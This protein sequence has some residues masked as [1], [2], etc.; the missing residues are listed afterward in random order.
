MKKE[1]E[2]GG[3]KERGEKERKMMEKKRDEMT[4]QKKV[5]WRNLNP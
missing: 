3:E 4:E 2:G 1:N 5:T